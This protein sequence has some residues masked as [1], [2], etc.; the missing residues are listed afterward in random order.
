[1]R[2]RKNPLKKM[3]PALI[4]A[5]GLLIAAYPYV[6]NEIYKN[7]ASSVITSNE[8][9]MENVS[10]KKLDE[11]RKQAYRYNSELVN[12]VG[13]LHDPFDTDVIKKAPEGYESQLSVNGSPIMGEI[14]IPQI[15]V[16]LPIYHGT[17][18][19]VL[20]AGCGHL[21]G[22]SLPVGGKS[23]HSVITGHTGLRNKKIFTDLELL[24][25]GDV[26]YIR[27]LGKKL[28]YRV[29]DINVVLPGDTDSLSIRDGEDLCTLVTCTPYGVND[30]RLLVTGKRCS[31]SKAYEKTAG[32]GRKSQWMRDYETW[33]ITGLV[34]SLLLV[35]ADR[36]RGKIRNDRKKKK[37]RDSA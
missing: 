32:S 16:K 13:V 4:I 1:M 9:S 30:H 29:C 25:V 14:V 23:T 5:T 18:Q 7:R 3:V 26:F 19:T 8:K 15:D 37:D 34:L 35:V 27:V 2:F 24:S 33:I 17:S 11:I 36:I 6:S 12:R 10:K 20:E 22:T 31:D 21:E 28:C